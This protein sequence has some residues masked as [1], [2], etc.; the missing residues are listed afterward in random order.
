ME[1]GEKIKAFKLDDDKG[2]PFS[3]ND[4]I[5]LSNLVIY[6]YPKDDTP[7]CT[8]QAC[9]FRDEFEAFNDLNAKVIGISSDDAQSHAKFKEKYRLPFT[10]LS[11]VNNR[12]SELF[13]V[14][15]DLFGLLPGRVTFIIDTKGIVRYKFD[16]RINIKKHIKESIRILESIKTA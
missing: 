12:V 6:F 1:I 2:M 7:G 14:K 4:H 5:G 8:I 16:S 11:D 10:L 9:T 3:I 15:R 13:K